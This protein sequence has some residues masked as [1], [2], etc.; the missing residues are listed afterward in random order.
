MNFK[1]LILFLSLVIVSCHTPTGDQKVIGNY[2]DIKSLLSESSSAHNY[3]IKVIKKV[4]IDGKEEEKEVKFDLKKF[5]EEMEILY[6]LDINQ[7]GLVGAYQETKSG[8][9]IVYQLKSDQR[10]TG[11]I[12]LKVSEE[13]SLKKINGNFLEKNNLYYSNREFRIIIKNNQLSSYQV[14]GSQ[15]MMFKDTVSFSVHLE[16]QK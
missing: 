11:I 3:P 9:E 12:Q 10:Q 14:I 5:Q 1:L 7:S 4:Q 16:I 6:V 13:G 8:N 15:K 2:Y